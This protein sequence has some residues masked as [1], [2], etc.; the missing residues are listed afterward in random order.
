M[1]V[2][3][4]DGRYMF[5]L[6]LIFEYCIIIYLAQIRFLYSLP[7]QNHDIYLRFFE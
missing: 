5:Y 3:H 4:F 1:K 7:W 6:V 2:V